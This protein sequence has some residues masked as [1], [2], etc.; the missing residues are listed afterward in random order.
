MIQTLTDTARAPG[1]PGVEPTT[2]TDPG[3]PPLAVGRR[4]HFGDTA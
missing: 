4:T 2:A 3:R 1:T